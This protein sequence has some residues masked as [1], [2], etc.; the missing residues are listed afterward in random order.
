[1][2]EQ[3]VFTKADR[4]VSEL[5]V[6]LIEAIARTAKEGNA[7]KVDMGDRSERAIKRF[8]ERL[9]HVGKAA[10]RP[11]KVCTRYSEAEKSLYI[12]ATELKVTDIGLDR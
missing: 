3:V 1:M 8:S 5:P 4:P 7:I 11:Y 2:D 10:A 6:K 9:R 12:W